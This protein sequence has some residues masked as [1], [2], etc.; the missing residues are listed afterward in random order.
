MSVNDAASDM[1]F[2]SRAIELARRGLY[3]TKPN[4]RVGCVIVKNNQIIAE[5]FHNKAGEDHAEIVAL[6]QLKNM[7]DAK[8]TD[9][10]VTLEPCSH[11]GK[12]PP[13]CDALIE[14]QRRSHGLWYA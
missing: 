1:A 7:S 10:Y 6:K 3:T 9:V 11:T 13:C 8:G 2:M 12:T 4:P 14:C 5:G